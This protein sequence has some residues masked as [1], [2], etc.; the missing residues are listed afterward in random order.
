MKNQQTEKVYRHR[1]LP[2]IHPVGGAF[3]ITTLTDDALPVGVYENLKRQ[4][5]AL[6]DEIWQDAFS[7]KVERIEQVRQDFEEELDDMLARL[8]SQEHPFRDPVAAQA[9]VDRLRMYDGQYYRLGA[10]SVMSNHLHLLLDLSIQVPHEW[11][12]I[13]PLENYKSLSE[14]LRLIKGGSAYDVNRRCHRQGALWRK[15]YYDRYIRSPSHYRQ[16][17]HYI[18]NNPVKAGLVRDWREHPFTSAAA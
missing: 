16:V 8:H 9:V 10:Y 18:V 15:G 13:S 14:V 7:D 11:D 3:S 17:C 12:G 2:H 5:D 1:N 4:R 6:L